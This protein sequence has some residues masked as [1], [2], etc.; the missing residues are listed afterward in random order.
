MMKLE[1]IF[2]AG[3]SYIDCGPGICVD[4]K[5]HSLGLHGVSAFN[6]K[7]LNQMFQKN[8]KTGL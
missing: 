2:I 4:P 7:P 3:L 8:L 5:I 6:V 1:N